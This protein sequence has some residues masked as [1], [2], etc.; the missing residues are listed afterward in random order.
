MA[1]VTKL[2]EIVEAEMK[3]FNETI[4]NY[5]METPLGYAHWLAQT[6]Y[7]VRHSTRLLAL[8][9]ANLGWDRNDL[10]NRFI[11]HTREER[12]HDMMALSDLKSLG[13][14]LES[15][16]ELPETQ[17]FYQTQYYWVEHVSPL[18]FFGYILCL[19]AASVN[20]GQSLYQRAL[21]AHGQRPTVFLKVH[22]Q[23][24]VD[25]VKKA[26]EQL[27]TF[28][29]K[30][31]V[32]ITENLKLSCHLYRQIYEKMKQLAKQEKSQAA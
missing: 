17:A 18:A 9:C 4:Q 22:V 15:F 5:P 16:P 32:A 21:K 1:N 10:H 23:E 20:G 27:A 30:D 13:F 29:E 11:D 28:P 25:H 8:C 24:D 3:K 14:K 2:I 31:L 19:E 26:Y 6:H 12:G 7:F